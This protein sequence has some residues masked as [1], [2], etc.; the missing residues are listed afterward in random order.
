M[1]NAMINANTPAQYLQSGIQHGNGLI[2]QKCFLAA[3]EDADA[4]V[5][6]FPSRIVSPTSLEML[7]FSDM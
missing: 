6:Y 4:C 1:L 2:S 3:A 5:D 7:H